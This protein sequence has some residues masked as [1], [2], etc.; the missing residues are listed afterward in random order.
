M[1][2]RVLSVIIIA[3]IPVLNAGCSKSVSYDKDVQSIL[4]DSCL[5]CHDGTGEGSKKSG[6]NVTDYNTLMKGTK[7]GPV[8][9]PGSSASSTLYRLID[10]KS[11]PEIQMPPHHD[12]ALAEGKAR[13]LKD[14]QIATIKEWIDQGAKDN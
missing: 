14:A 10:H 12:E 5:T 7:T 4:N 3:A 6:F 8:V 9:V 11:D 1:R 13:P 2:N